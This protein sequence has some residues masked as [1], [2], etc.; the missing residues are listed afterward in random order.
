[1]A[2]AQDKGVH[3]F[4]A[5]YSNASLSSCPTYP[6]SSSCK[7]PPA[8]TLGDVLGKTTQALKARGEAI[9]RGN[10]L[11]LL[12]HACHRSEEHNIC[13]AN[14][15]P[16]VGVELPSDAEVSTRDLDPG[17]LNVPG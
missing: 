14:P 4:P 8:A 16:S 17:V 15:F 6:L 10:A 13:G 11:S 9:F 5:R 2:R 12:L 1:M 3:I 7:T